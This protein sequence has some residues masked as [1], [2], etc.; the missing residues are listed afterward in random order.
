MGYPPK[1]QSN[2]GAGKGKLREQTKIE[3][4]PLGIFLKMQSRHAREKREG[5]TINESG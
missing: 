4:D 5:M 3:K 2:D 1:K